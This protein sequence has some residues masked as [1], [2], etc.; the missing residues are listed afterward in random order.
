[1]AYDLKNAKT[2]LEKITT[3]KVSKEDAKKLYS[4]LKM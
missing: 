2:F 3:Q 1:M 4:D